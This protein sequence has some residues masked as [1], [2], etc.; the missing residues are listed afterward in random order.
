MRDSRPRPFAK[1]SRRGKSPPC[2]AGGSVTASGSAG[3]TRSTCTLRAVGHEA[4]HDSP[5]GLSNTPNTSWPTVLIAP[6]GRPR[7][8]AGVGSPTNPAHRLVETRRVSGAGLRSPQ[9]RVAWGGGKSTDA[10][11]QLRSRDDKIE[12]R[13]SNTL[14]ALR[15]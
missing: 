2:F 9:G 8:G 11:A 5:V 14:H 4:R 6:F 1:H 7:L 15:T 13:N 3:S 10:H 12:A